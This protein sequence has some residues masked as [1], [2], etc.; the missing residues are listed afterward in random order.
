MIKHS[1]KAIALILSL[2]MVLSAFPLGLLASAEDNVFQ[3]TVKA[4]DTA[5]EG[6]KV[7]LYSKNT[8]VAS[9]S[10]GVDGV[11]LF[12]D[13][14]DEQLSSLTKAVI[15]GGENSGCVPGTFLRRNYDFDFSSA[16]VYADNVISAEDVVVTYGEQLTLDVSSLD[17]GK[18][19]YKVADSNIAEVNE[20]GVVTP[21]NTGNTILEIYAPFSA[22]YADAY[23]TVGLTVMP[24]DKAV[25][26]F[27]TAGIDHAKEVV[28]TNKAIL[29]DD[30]KGT[31]KYTS[32]DATYASVNE[33][34]GELKVLKGSGSAVITATFT[35]DEDCKN[36]KESVLTYEVSSEYVITYDKDNQYTNAGLIEITGLFT[37]EKAS[38]SV[39]SD[40]TA[41]LINGSSVNVAETG[42]IPQGAHDVTIYIDGN[43]QKTFR[44]MK[45]TIKPD[46][47]VVQPDDVPVE[48]KWLKDLHTIYINM[49]QDSTPGS[50]VKTISYT[51]HNY[52]GDS[53]TTKTIDPIP[54]ALRTI[55]LAPSVFADGKSSVK[56]CVTDNAGNK[57]EKEFFVLK[58]TTEPEVELSYKNDDGSLWFDKEHI[59]VV[60][61]T[62][63]NEKENIGSGVASVKYALNSNEDKAYKEVRADNDGKYIIDCSKINLNA[64]RNELFVRVE[65]NVGNITNQSVILNYD[66]GHAEIE[67][68]YEK[69]DAWRNDISEADINITKL[70]QSESGIRSIVYEV[71]KQ[72]STKEPVTTDV[73]DTLKAGSSFSP[74]DLGI[75]EDG[76]YTV[77]FIATNN[78][79][80]PTAAS[81][82]VKVDMTSPSVGYFDFDVVGETSFDTLANALTFGKFFN[83]RLKVSVDVV[84]DGSQVDAKTTKLVVTDAKTGDET[85]V[86]CYSYKNNKAVFYVDGNPNA[87]SD[88]KVFEGT[89]AIK[90]VDT[91]GNSEANPIPATSKNSDTI[92]AIMWEQV[93]PEISISAVP[94]GSEAGI[95]KDA[96]AD[97]VWY[98]SAA[99]VV[100]A[101]DNDSGIKDAVIKI[102]DTVVAEFHAET[103][104]DIQK[105]LVFDE[106]K[107]N[108]NGVFDGGDYIVTADVIDAAGNEKIET[109][110][111][112][113]DSYN[114]II[115]GFY[116]NDV[117]VNSELS[118]YTDDNGF[119]PK[120]GYYFKE[121]TKVKITASDIGL[122]SEN[123]QVS[124]GLKTI[125]YK[126]VKYG[127]KFDNVEYTSVDVDKDGAITFIAPAGFRGNIFAIATDNVGRDSDD[128][129]TPDSIVIETQDAHNQTTEEHISMVLDGYS[130]GCYF[131]S[132]VTPEFTIRDSF[133]GIKSVKITVSGDTIKEYSEEV[134]CENGH[135]GWKATELN[136]KNKQFITSL[137]KAIE[138]DANCNN[139]KIT[140]QMA[141]NCG[142]TSEAVYSFNIDMTAPTA[143]TAFEN[144]ADSFDLRK[145]WSN[146]S[147]NMTVD[148]TE[149]EIASVAWTVEKKTDNGE[150]AKYDA[151]NAPSFAKTTEGKEVNKDDN[152]WSASYEFDEEGEYRVSYVVADKAGNTFKSDTY[153]FAIDKS[154]PSVAKV[155]INGKNISEFK[156]EKNGNK[157]ISIGA[158]GE[159]GS[160]VVTLD[161]GKGCG[162]KGIEYF[163][164]DE[165]GTQSEPKFIAVTEGTA[166]AE[167][168]VENGFIGEL[169]VAT[170]DNIDN[171]SDNIN[172]VYRTSETSDEHNSKY[173]LDISGVEDKA[174]YNDNSRAIHV[175][176][177]DPAGISKIEWNITTDTNSSSGV[178][179]GEGLDDYG[180]NVDYD[181]VAFAD[182]DLV[183]SEWVTAAK[184]TFTVTTESNNIKV[185]IKYSDMAGNTEEKNVTFHIDR[186]KPIINV[187]LPAYD[188]SIQGE[189]DKTL[190]YKT[191]VTANIAVGELNY[192][193]LSVEVKR[194]GE[195]YAEYDR[196]PEMVDESA[197][198]VSHNTD[199]TFSED[200]KYEVKLSV[201]DLANN[202]STESFSFVIDKKAPVITA[203]NFYKEAEELTAL[204]R[205]VNIF[206]FGIFYND[207][208]KVE[209]IAEDPDKGTSASGIDEYVV[210]LREN[211]TVHEFISK[212]NIIDIPYDQLS[213]VAPAE[214]FVRVKDNVGNGG[215]NA[216]LKSLADIETTNAYTSGTTLLLEKKAP[217]IEI[218]VPEVDINNGERYEEKLDDDGT[219]KLWFKGDVEITADIEDSGVY[220]AGIRNIVV[221]VNDKEYLKNSYE[222]NRMEATTVT[223][224]TKDI[225]PDENCAYKI[226]VLVYDNA[227]NK[228]TAETV[229]Y[230][231]AAAPIIKKIKIE[232]IAD[233]NSAWADVLNLLT[234]GIFY[235]NDVSVQVEAEDPTPA[236]GVNNYTL[237]V[238]D[239]EPVNS[240]DGKFT[241][242][243]KEYESLE[244]I[245]I[246]AT[247]K[248]GNTCEAVTPTS[249]GIE[250]NAK[251][252][253]IMLEK[254]APEIRI[255]IP[256]NGGEGVDGSSV[257]RYE[258][259]DKIWYSADVNFDVEVEDIKSGIRSVRAAING[260][261]VLNEQLNGNMVVSKGYKLPTT[262]ANDKITGYVL[263]VTVYDN[264]GN[265]FT[266]TKTVYIDTAKPTLNSIKLSGADENSKW[267]DITN[268]LTFGT[269]YNNDVSVVVDA[270]DIYTGISKYVLTVG[271]DSFES[272][273]GKFVIPFDDSV[274][275]RELK[276]TIVD[277][278]GH[279]YVVEGQAFIDAA[280]PAKNNT[281]L[282]D[283]TLSDINANVSYDSET[284]S[285]YRKNDADWYS[286]NVTFDVNVSDYDSG[287]SSIS[288]SING[289]ELYSK[290]F[291]ANNEITETASFSV[292]TG[293]GSVKQ[294]S[295]GEYV[296]TVTVIDNAGNATTYDKTIYKDTTPPVIK[297]VTFVGGNENSAWQDALN[298]LTFG[299][300]FNN[301]VRV[302]IE[303]EDPDSAS[304]V[305]NYT[306]YVGDGEPVYSDDGE[307]TISF[308][309]Y[310][311][312]ETIKIAATDMVGNTCDPVMPTNEGVTTN[313]QNNQILLESALPGIEI[314]IPE[315][316]VNGVKRYD[317]DTKVWY[318]GDIDFTVNVSDEQS[319]IRSVSA[320]VNGTELV[321]D[322]LNSSMVKSKTYTVSTRA[323]NV[324]RNDDGSYVIT[325]TVVDNAGNRYKQDKV[326]YKDD[327]APEVTNIH[328]EAKDSTLKNLLSLLTFGTFFNNN[329]TVT[330]E[331]RD[332]GVA[333]G[334]KSYELYFG[335]KRV[336]ASEKG[337]FAVDYDEFSGAPGVISAVAIDNVDNASNPTKPS[338]LNGNTNAMHNEMLLEKDAPVIGIT[339]PGNGVNDVVRFD[340]DSKVWYSNDIDFSIAVRDNMSGIKNITA[341][342]NGKVLVNEM[343]NNG[344]DI[345]ND[346]TVKV[347]TGADGV[348]ANADGSY[349]LTV[350]ATDNAGNKTEEVKQI[351]Y[352]DRTAPRIT[353]IAFIDEKGNAKSASEVIGYDKTSDTYIITCN[354]SVQVI[355]T[356]I[357]E[358]PSAALNTVPGSD[359]FIKAE[360][361]SLNGDTFVPVDANI[362]CTKDNSNDTTV[363]QWSYTLEQ[364]FKGKISATVEDNVGNIS[365]K[366]DPGHFI[367]ETPE[368]HEQEVN[369]ITMELDSY[370]PGYFYNHVVTPVINI[371][372]NYAGVKDIKVEITAN[373]S[374][375]KT[376]EA[377]DISVGNMQ[378]WTAKTLDKNHVSVASMAIPVAIESNDIVI[379]VEMTD[380]SYNVSR[381]EYN[382]NIDLTNPVISCSISSAATPINR[383]YSSSVTA[384]ITVVE[385]N[386]RPEFFEIA[387]GS[388]NGW[389]QNGDAWTTSAVFAAEG[390]HNFTLR[391]T[392]F[393]GNVGNSN[394]SEGTFYVDNTNPTI[395][396]NQMVYGQ[397]NNSSDDVSFTI[398]ASD[399][400]C[401]ASS[402]LST[403]FTVWYKDVAED[404]AATIVE[405]Q[406]TLD[407][408]V[409]Q[410]FIKY[411][412]VPG[413]QAFS[414]VIT[415]IK[416]EI[417]NDG[418]Y[419]FNCLVTDMSGRTSNTLLYKNED[420]S[421]TSSP[422]F[423]LSLNRNGST[424]RVYWAKSNQSVNDSAVD[425]AG[426]IVIEEKNPNP[427]QTDAVGSKIS[428]YD[429]VDHKNVDAKVTAEK[430]KS[431]YPVY[432]YNVSRSDYFD[433][434]G[435]YTLSIESVDAS[436][437]VSNGDD[438]NFSSVDFII[439]TSAPIIKTDLKSKDIQEET[440]H[441]YSITLE[442]L[443]DCK[444]SVK[445]ENDEPMEVILGDG[446]RQKADGNLELKG[447]AKTVSLV[448]S[449]D[450]KNVKIFA[451]DALN[452]KAEQLEFNSI[453]IFTS[454][455]KL[456]F[457]KMNNNPW[458][459]A[460]IAAV[461]VGAIV[462]A[463]IVA[464]KR[465]K[466]E[467]DI[468]MIEKDAKKK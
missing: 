129:V 203:V 400:L 415:L 247:D 131:N 311:A 208:V 228:S 312:L 128:I 287:I 461:P 365:A 84:D 230:K 125:D 111:F 309:E 425:N 154:A 339:I 62:I 448:L 165:N 251:N 302:Q 321:T 189:T 427:I 187:T 159:N 124:S 403:N 466:D 419:S 428:V 76:I 357:D 308:K 411:T 245:R 92:G 218:T 334:V 83:K 11:A 130:D 467:N 210:C 170:F 360:F 198:P 207:T 435:M 370:T 385:H 217:E 214:I 162:A 255:G 195:E 446:T 431:K 397:T 234:F 386:F 188:Y 319:G 322:N 242:S 87:G 88:E 200:G 407:E 447:L 14:T 264:A 362:N 112:S 350:T 118:E 295:N 61:V 363:Y 348:V 387:G 260:K 50:A 441:T 273:D 133:A 305:K 278:T 153:S 395:T 413:S 280:A 359:C 376:I 209:I 155:T 172:V 456:V 140:V 340:G 300:F 437:N 373:G 101:A 410:G 142:N 144:S 229:I 219:S 122:D 468:S 391:A 163:T 430:E 269:F 282:F 40:S 192:N 103:I 206:T 291:F 252:N 369:H 452:H 55:T 224:S 71:S 22:D 169:Y 201:T 345:V 313:A 372:D 21:K 96:E 253:S 306:L 13:I 328:F 248:V 4:D 239:G 323:E 389:T 72:N 258:E 286:D 60:E 150:Y 262:A 137:S 293:S 256:E 67:V 244:T 5:V 167:F 433:T 197:I 126:I 416:S 343:L 23:R 439:D 105:E 194:N 277:N 160:V 396:V 191:D 127:E 440:E 301:D 420:G 361:T 366:V 367:I 270:E 93:E 183:E 145:I 82:V 326:V 121:N 90:A 337:V 222:T 227:G 37:G 464:K 377:H 8:E 110:K 147:V 32:S 421:S 236:S 432:K 238:G 325:V 25:D 267:N 292:N 383:Y 168:A 95:Y 7:T 94:E 417:D 186:T 44:V 223:V 353:S 283:K 454:G 64:S 241:I 381:T 41:Y 450:I 80:V 33:T 179:D 449:G 462:I 316:G 434:D 164:V 158:T 458:I 406:F 444:L 119:D 196:K 98:D 70:T 250:S 263:V 349:E 181:K 123:P 336:G 177:A 414:Y 388:V 27:E 382:F 318:S 202:T 379:K 193:G 146:S 166:D 18:L 375:Y 212:N 102:N 120:F 225:A 24:S 303:A 100:T 143:V 34:T 97:K 451:A 226:D 443:T 358:G 204:E 329:V 355:M 271:S 380:N 307:F 254:N 30:A 243:Y 401:L 106:L 320:A 173:T 199:I 390:A 356:A 156:D 78:A 231:D 148:V 429:G 171:K 38:F 221:N 335:G 161:D 344:E 26:S 56:V 134:V 213:D 16:K 459:Y 19:S 424:Y 141:D 347:S 423:E 42:E 152:M 178:L 299:I 438:K 174:Y 149:R 29:K 220:N 91:V 393:A 276:L 1:K 341:S 20:Y 36:Y 422:N 442:D 237:Y 107:L 63:S 275:A 371:K 279:E 274:G 317:T 45:D 463:L 116:F 374:S 257:V 86:D 455:I 272:T 249:E 43:I 314:T 53:T 266:S 184:K 296:L 2:L 408:L 89:V 405:K 331:G 240:D 182:T 139:I 157:I 52:N 298:L 85:L 211:D 12:A 68:T 338:D 135:D 15:A 69:N 109:L 368:L 108:N 294:G 66:T 114:P 233:E 402:P 378:G 65:D 39:D 54:E 399:A 392:D 136:E 81:V 297:K 9:A 51:I 58:D 77:T 426:D 285:H 460:V 324:K 281:L 17:G 352:I 35:P 246:T 288:A 394:G 418:I 404:G 79:G 290:V 409:Q 48:G 304:G 232:G 333:C 99:P 259:N 398:T 74:E 75:E 59:P 436:G 346:K 113:V 351:V 354:E 115:T 176:I 180:W 151:F 332:P 117:A 265:K 364:N 330:V 215:E 57:T 412:T 132:K 46:F 445:D 261:E 49:I 315:D 384:S 453:T 47:Q 185:Y 457:A 465:K 138:I 310:E 175:N 28:Y 3:F 205:A 10:S 268:L 104:D 284:V 289:T 327:T 190:F 342:V 31:V 6:A 216:D 235:N 73:T